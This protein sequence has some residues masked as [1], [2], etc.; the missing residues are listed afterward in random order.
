[1]IRALGRPDDPTYSARILVW[2]NEALQEISA[3]DWLFMKQTATVIIPVSPART[4][5]YPAATATVGP[6]KSTINILYTD[7]GGSRYLLTPATRL[8]LLVHYRDSDTDT[9]PAYFTETN[10]AWE[11]WPAHTTAGGVT[12]VVEYYAW[13]T[14]IPTDTD[15]A[16]AA[17]GL[18]LYT[19]TNEIL[20]HYPDI[21][22]Y[23]VIV[24][25]Y[26]DGVGNDAMIGS[27]YQRYAAAYERLVRTN[28]GKQ[29]TLVK[30]FTTPPRTSYGQTA[31]G[32]TYRR[33]Q[34][35]TGGL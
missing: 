20:D 23:L 4:V 34:Y 8:G 29:A 31:G 3:D 25:G 6:Y 2:A 30:A 17:L 18:G 15:P 7:T 22:K 16:R 10:T 19:F 1:M 12:A 9:Y 11:F 5:P 13:L 35:N 32:G 21:L 14:E 27:Y 33:G 24:K 26:A 28:G